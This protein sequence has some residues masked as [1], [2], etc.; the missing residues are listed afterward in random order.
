M[1]AV[2]HISAEDT[3]TSDSDVQ[4]KLHSFVLLILKSGEFPLRDLYLRWLYNALVVTKGSTYCGIH[5]T[6]L[7]DYQISKQNIPIFYH[8]PSVEAS[9]F[10]TVRLA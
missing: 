3:R 9:G 7:Q 5:K 1:I 2:L 10:R 4:E 8:P 6:D